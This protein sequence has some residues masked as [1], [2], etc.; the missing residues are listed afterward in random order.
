[1]LVL[2][3]VLISCL[4]HAYLMFVLVL[5]RQGVAGD[6]DKPATAVLWL[7]HMVAALCEEADGTATPPPRFAPAGARTF[8]FAYV[9]KSQS[10]MVICDATA[11]EVHATSLRESLL[12]ERRLPLVIEMLLTRL[13]QLQVTTTPTLPVCLTGACTINRPFITMHD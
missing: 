12:V 2:V 8:L 9:G 13:T 3:L 5:A 7:I 10:C 6:D 1:M 11:T 4:S